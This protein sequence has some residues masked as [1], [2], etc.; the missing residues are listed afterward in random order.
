MRKIQGFLR[1]FTALTLSALL[2]ATGLVPV[3]AAADSSK[4]VTLGVDLSSSQQSSILKYFGVKGKNVTTIYINNQDER[5]L[6]GS[7]IP[8]EV[9][10][11]HTYSCAYVQPT[12]SGGIHVKT[13]NLSYVTSNMIASALTTS[14]IKNC[15]VIAAC[16][17]EVSGT[18]ALTGVLKAYE[19]ATGR[20]LDPGKKRAAAQEIVTTG[21]I[22]NVIGQTQATN[23]INKVKVEVVNDGL[24]GSDM[25][26]IRDIVDKAVRDAMKDQ[27]K[28][29]T[30]DVR[31]L[32]PEDMQLIDDLAKIIA[33]QQY[34]IDDMR[35]TMDMVERNM[36]DLIREEEERRNREAE[37]ADDENQAAESDK[38]SIPDSVIFDVNDEADSTA[39]DGTESED[40]SFGD[41]EIPED[42]ATDSEPEQPSVFDEDNILINTDDSVFDEDV[43]VDATD[44]EALPPEH[45]NV[46][47]DPEPESSEELPFDITVTDDDGWGGWDSFE[48]DTDENDES[49]EDS[50]S[51][52]DSDDPW[53]G[54]DTFDTESNDNQAAGD[55]ADDSDDPWEGWDSFDT[56]DS[57][58]QEN[59]D[60]AD[61]SGDA[62]DSFD[63]TGDTAENTD[64]SGSDEGSGDEWTDWDSFENEG[65]SDETGDEFT[66]GNG[67]ASDDWT[68]E[69]ASDDWTDEGASDDWTDE[70]AS[71]DW[72][73]EGASDD[74]TGE[75]GADETSD[76]APSV[77]FASDF[78]SVSVALYVEGDLVP[79]SGQIVLT[80][81][82]G[83]E[84]ARISLADESAWAARSIS[85]SGVYTGFDGNEIRIFTGSL[86]LTDSSYH[87]S[88]DITFADNAGGKAAAGTEKPSVQGE[89]DLYFEASSLS[90][91]S[92]QRF[93]AGSQ[94]SLSLRFPEEAAY[95]SVIS[96]DDSVAVP[97]S[98]F[99]EPGSGS[100]SVSLG[101]R[102]DA[103]I[104][105]AF[106]DSDDSVISEESI[107]FSV[108]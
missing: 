67:D 101:S 2:A 96:S 7:F 56:D 41:D 25:A 74:W 107:S 19:T 98:D 40:Y 22:A 16:P 104:I 55:T 76:T 75:A 94:A 78:N 42:E 30:G 27:E 100:V 26:K 79:A 83:S 31:T 91:T 1:K 32:T 93:S 59:T 46:D 57:G 45:A 70:G 28:N 49:R 89:A 29:A 87:L 33:E 47:T 23:I 72:T 18:G 4:V 20:T 6:L 92:S 85:D 62:W 102:G 58:S 71:D 80:D 3:T 5:E 11:T 38:D 82:T 103:E 81:S 44:E 54:W 8:L 15:N 66:E 61:D 69:G 105:V 34:Q 108:F 68:D 88:A 13:A 64:G 48:P 43:I 73:D 52:D 10:G 37:N 86:A 99:L 95:A 63:G 97:D 9:I 35:E 106:Y 90:L 39:G 17:F 65:G 60:T 77:I 36:E 84:A 51:S 53:E 21:K 24:T 50:D 14:G 12:S